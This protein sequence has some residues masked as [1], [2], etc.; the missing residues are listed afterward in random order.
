LVTPAAMVDTS[1]YVPCLAS[2]LPPDSVS[3]LT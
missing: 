3:V 1:A 2:A